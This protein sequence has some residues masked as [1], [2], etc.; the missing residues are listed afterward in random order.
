MKESEERKPWGF[1]ETPEAKCTMNYCDENGCQNR[2]R[3]YAPLKSESED[4]SARAEE[5]ENEIVK[6]ANE[7]W[8]NQPKPNYELTLDEKIQRS[9]GYTV[10][11]KDGYKSCLAAQSQS[12]DGSKLPKEIYV[13]YDKSDGEVFCAYTSKEQCEYDAKDGGCAMQSVILIIEESGISEKPNNHIESLEKK[14][15]Q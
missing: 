14:L 6:I 8:K 5:R 3:T 4:I 1:C 12:V 9:G 10:G 13:T 11:F 15:M 7:S 2:K